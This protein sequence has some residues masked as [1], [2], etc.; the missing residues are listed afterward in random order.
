MGS[1]RSRP[2]GGSAERKRRKSGCAPSASLSTRFSSGPLVQSMV[3]WM[4]WSSTQPPLRWKLAR[5]A[6][7]M[8]SW[9]WPRLTLTY[10]PLSAVKPRL[11]PSASTE[12]ATS[13][14]GERKT[15]MGTAALASA[16]LRSRLKGTL[17]VNLASMTVRTKR[18]M[19]EVRR[20][21]R[22]ARKRSSWSKSGMRFQSP[23]S[24]S[25]SGRSSSSHSRQ[26]LA[27]PCR[28]SG[29]EA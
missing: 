8:G 19:A 12:A 14:P 10:L 7:A 5:C 28:S 24:G 6:I 25:S 23:G 9:P 13:T 21:G 4:F 22:S 3:R 20:S 26:R 11:R 15:N 18:A 27:L 2:G 17:R 1:G 29:S 16:K